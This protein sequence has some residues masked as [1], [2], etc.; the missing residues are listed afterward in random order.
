MVVG[1]IADSAP[2]GRADCRLDVGLGWAIGGLLAAHPPGRWPA[3]IV[4]RKGKEV[5]NERQ[6]ETR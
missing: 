4:L 3:A 5:Q 1:A 2:P 6:S